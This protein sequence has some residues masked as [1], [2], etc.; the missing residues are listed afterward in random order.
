M[1]IAEGCRITGR[2]RQGN[3]WS[4]GVTLTELLVV[5]TII[6]ALAAVSVPTFRDG[7]HKARVK[8]AVEDIRGLLFQA[9]VEGPIRDRNMSIAI[10]PAAWC[11]GFSAM[12]RCDCRIE[13]GAEACVIDVAGHPVVQ[14]VS[15]QAFPGVV[16]TSTFP[17][18][19]ATLNR[20]R[21]TLSPAGTITVASGAWKADIRA[22]LYGRLR[23]CT[24]EDA[25][26]IAGYGRC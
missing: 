7:L 6:A 23:V 22:S 10:D 5:V 18:D 13:A 17:G 3:Y 16:I 14:R 12:P 1:K 19:T 20:L 2:C 9:R 26:P 15:G 11:V 24:P 21:G 25:S 4:S 8:R